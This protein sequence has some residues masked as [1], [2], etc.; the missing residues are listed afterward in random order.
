VNVKIDV[1][2]GDPATGITLAAIDTQAD[3]IVMATHGRTGISR[4][5]QGSVAGMVLRTG[6]TP[7]VL[8]HPQAEHM[9]TGLPSEHSLSEQLGPAPT[10]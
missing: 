8:V 6:T 9:A 1:R 10:F 2:F 3:V 5:M 7:V 4:A